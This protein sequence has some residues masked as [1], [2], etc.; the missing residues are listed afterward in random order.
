MNLLEFF[1]NSIFPINSHSLPS[2][3]HYNHFSEEITLF[4]IINS[5][6][7]NIHDISEIN[8]QDDR[9]EAFFS[10]VF[11][12]R[13][14]A[15]YMYNKLHNQLVLG[16]YDGQLYNMACNTINNTLH[17]SFNKLQ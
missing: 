8:I 1:G 3:F 10:I 15:E 5:N 14:I 2:E 4:N 13:S 7:D 6:I 16:A 17:L 9:G 11:L 12:N